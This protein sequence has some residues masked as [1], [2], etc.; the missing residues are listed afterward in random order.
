MKFGIY[1]PADIQEAKRILSC[2]LPPLRLQYVLDGMTNSWIK[3]V[4]DG[5][6]LT[7]ENA[8]DDYVIRMGLNYKNQGAL[9]GQPD[10]SRKRRQIQEDYFFDL[11]PLSTHTTKRNP[12]T[13]S[14]SNSNA[15]F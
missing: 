12:R 5:L 11:G 3:T 4:L 2:P 15:G 8:E 6:I 13:N 9:L 14:N 1:L 7:G 10:R